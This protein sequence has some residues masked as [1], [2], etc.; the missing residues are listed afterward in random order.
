MVFRRFY[1]WPL[2]RVFL[3]VLA[4]FRPVIVFQLFR[5]NVRFEWF[6]KDFRDFLYNVSGL[7]MV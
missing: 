3:G 5:K 7:G 6:C 4:S 2:V 1:T